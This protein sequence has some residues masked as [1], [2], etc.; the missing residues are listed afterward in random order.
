MERNK[1]SVRGT[2]KRKTRD[3]FLW[4]KGT[5]MKWV[6]CEEERER[7]HTYQIHSCLPGRAW[8][9]SNITAF[10]WCSSMSKSRLVLTNHTDRIPVIW[11]RAGPVSP[12]LVTGS[13]LEF[14]GKVAFFLNGNTVEKM[15]LFSFWMLSCLNILCEVTATVV[16]PLPEEQSRKTEKLGSWG[17]DLTPLTNPRRVLPYVG[18]LIMQDNTFPYCWSYLNST[19]F[20]QSKVL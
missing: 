3:G 4:Q 9:C 10:T 17:C 14:L 15:T 6:R 1:E 19:F 13:L 12:A 18:L 8:V 7:N 20:L 2:W 16:L 11:F 5:H